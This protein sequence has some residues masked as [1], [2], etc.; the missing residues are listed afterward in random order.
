M[1]GRLLTDRIGGAAPRWASLYDPRRAKP[2]S[3]AGPALKLQA[4]V[5]RQFMGDRLSSDVDSV[6]QIP[7][8]QGAVTRRIGGERC[9]VYATVA[10]SSQQSRPSAPTSAA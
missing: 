10:A 6:D 4:K 2:T 7:P 8:G 3:E 1:A 5:A 9:A